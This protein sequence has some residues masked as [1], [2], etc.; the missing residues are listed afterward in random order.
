MDRC[1]EIEVDIIFDGQT[2]SVEPNVE[3]RI[4]TGNGKESHNSSAITDVKSSWFQLSSRK[5]RLAFLCNW[6]SYIENLKIQFCLIRFCLYYS[7]YFY[8]SCTL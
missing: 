7:F 6:H 2:N 5:K 8:F 4:Y 3:A 1:S